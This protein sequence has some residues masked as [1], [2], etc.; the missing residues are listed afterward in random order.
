MLGSVLRQIL[1]RPSAPSG[2]RMSDWSD[3]PYYEPA[4]LARQMH[5]KARL[6]RDSGYLH[7]PAL[8]HV[9]TLAVCNAACVF[10]PYPTLE[11]QGTRMPDELIEK[12]VADLGAIPRD[13]SFQFAPYK[14][15]EPFVESRL[16]DIIAL[17]NAR[18]PNARISL[19]TNASPLTG[20]K[21]EQLARARNV[22]YLNVS[23]NAVDAQ[24]YEALMKIPFARTVAR[25]DALHE[26]KRA[27]PLDFPVRLTRVSGG[28]TAD[29]D[30]TAWVGARYPS[31]QPAI[32]PRNDWI[33]E[34]PSPQALA[35][36]PDAPC[37]RWFD[38]SVTATGMVA[39]CC[40]D[41][42]AK[43]PKGDARTEH[44]LDIYNRPHLVR[45]RQAL[46]S[47]RAAGGPCDRCTYQSY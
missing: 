21:L 47:R 40:M 9:E 34:V 24:E 22:A 27:L 12:I 26:A 30:F 4:A 39:M 19:I 31:F 46:L 14:V 8:V 15:S 33:G 18:L 2:D 17:V 25:L 41:G 44:L 6:L 35:E 38:L 1:R 3:R 36:V 13:Q 7:V 37:H 28:R 42:E 16:F 43:Y 10:C 23:L 5:A 20:K 29:E 11:R 45:F 32:L